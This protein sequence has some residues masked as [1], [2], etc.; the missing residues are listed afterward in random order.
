M[1]LS[2]LITKMIPSFTN[3]HRKHNFMMF[4]LLFFFCF[5][6]FCRTFIAKLR[7]QS[8]FFCIPLFLQTCVCFCFLFFFCFGFCFFVLKLPDLDTWLKNSHNILLP[9]SNIATKDE[10]MELVTAVGKQRQWKLLFRGSS[11]DFDPAKFHRKCDNKGFC[12]ARSMFDF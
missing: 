4:C 6:V 2:T 10:L 12:F 9:E 5:F 8:F 3:Y 1:V 7:K 11:Y